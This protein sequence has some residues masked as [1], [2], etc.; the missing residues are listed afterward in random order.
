MKA[1]EFLKNIS[2]RIAIFFHNDSDGVCSAAMMLKFVKEADLYSGDI[3][4]DF[5]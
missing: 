5:Y 1:E 3:N 2:G 4:N